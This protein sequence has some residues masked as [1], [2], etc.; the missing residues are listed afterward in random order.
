MMYRVVFFQKNLTSFETSTNSTTFFFFFFSF[1]K[2]MEK[3]LATATLK[4]YT[5]PKC[6]IKNKKKQLTPDKSF[7]N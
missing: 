2:L 3:G 4:F 5:N 1:K 7:E 6:I